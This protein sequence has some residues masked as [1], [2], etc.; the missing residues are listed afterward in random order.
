MS[1]FLFRSSVGCFQ[2][3]TEQGLLEQ[4]AP[5]A[6]VLFHCPLLL[7]ALLLRQISL[8]LPKKVLVVMMMMMVMMMCEI[9]MRCLV[10]P[11]LCFHERGMGFALTV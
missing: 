3:N 5:Q 6:F 4:L 2:E 10:E 8:A 9:S 11:G 1:E 7:Q